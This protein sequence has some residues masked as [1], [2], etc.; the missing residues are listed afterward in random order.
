MPYR[1][2]PKTDAA[3][4]KALKT[5]LENNDI[6]TARNRFID[7]KVLNRARPIYER[8]LTA[9]EQHRISLASQTRNARKIGKLQYNATMYI[10][11]F[12]QVLLMSIDRGEIKRPLLELYGLPPETTT[13]PNLKSAD[14]I[15][16]WG[17][18]VVAGEKARLKKGGRPIYNPT[19]GMVS[20]HYDIFREA[21]EAQ[22]RLQERTAQALESINRLRP[23]CDEVLLE[24]WNSI[25]AHFAGLP[26]ERRFAACRKYGV[27]Y[28]YRRHEEHLY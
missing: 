3:R 27:V 16:E 17:A 22:K 18:K 24:L 6:Y 21:Y 19:V 8:L 4:I 2:L 10:S 12:V 28:Y 7:W 20:T 15:I 1:R 9:M 23:E 11:H 13:I 25:E 5:F 26:P 14:G